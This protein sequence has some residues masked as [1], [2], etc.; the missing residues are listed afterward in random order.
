MKKAGI[1]YDNISGN[2]GDMAIGLSVIKALKDGGARFDVLYPGNFNPEDY[3]TIIVGGGH[4]IRPGADIFYD[5][6]K[7]P[8]HHI[9]NAAGI[10]GSPDDLGYLDDYKYVTVRSNGD[11]VKLSCLKCKVHVVP[12]TT[13][14]LEDRKNFPLMPKK[15]SIGIHLFP[16]C[17]K[18]AEETSFIRWASSLPFNIYFIPITHYNRDISYMRDFSRQI[19]NSALL[20][21]LTPLEIFTLMGRLDHLI[22]CSMHGAIFSYVHNKPFILYESDEKIRFFMEDR[23]L[24]RYAF[25]NFSGLQTA[26]QDLCHNAPDYSA[27]I[28]SDR[29]TLDK[30]IDRILEFLP[31]KSSGL[32]PGL[33]TIRSSTSPGKA[34]LLFLQAEFKASFLL[35]SLSRSYRTG[36]ISRILRRK[37]PAAKL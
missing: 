37:V 35:A 6:F 31:Q 5:K 15:P 10:V 20:P 33:E 1:L 25:K 30:H 21:L 11:K 7:V 29:K 2:T 13:M 26:F 24:E 34:R 14:L 4:I 23:G 17:I 32:S 19:K 27:K 8:G 22:S 16:G 18:K 12:C 9:L 36:A 28:S 3:D